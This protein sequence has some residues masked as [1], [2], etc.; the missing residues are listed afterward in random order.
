MIIGLLAGGGWL[1]AVAATGVLRDAHY[2]VCFTPGGQC[3]NDIVQ[4]ISK[5][6]TT[7]DVQA[8]SFTSAPIAKAL[9]DAKR[10]DVNVFVLLDKS[11]VSNKYSVVT[12]LNNQHI[13][14]AIDSKPAIAH[15]KVMII[16]PNSSKAAVITGSFNFTKSAQVRN[17]ENV[18]IIDDQ[19]LAKQYLTNFEKRKAASVSYSQYCMSSTKCKL[20]STAKDVSKS[21]KK[22]GMRQK[23][24]GID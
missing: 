8:Y 22:A 14:F 13:P 11:N 15:N 12:M 3:T 10:R 19:N 4:A 2:T 1:S 7:I 18:M 23:K 21:L 16:D 5:A 20:K 17:A 9:I 24:L 6:K